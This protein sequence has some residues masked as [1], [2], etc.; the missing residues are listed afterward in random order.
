MSY[1]IEKTIK[2][3]GVEFQV[4]AEVSQDPCNDK[5]WTV[6]DLEIFIDDHEVYDVLGQ[7]VIDY[8]ESKIKEAAKVEAEYAK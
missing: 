8:L 7:S 3:S 1:T 6:E 2:Y 4:N 5:T